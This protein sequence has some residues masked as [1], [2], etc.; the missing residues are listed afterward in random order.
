[1][2][3]LVLVVLLTIVLDSNAKGILVPI[4]SCGKFM[5]LSQESKHAAIFWVSGY[6]SG[7]NEFSDVDYLVN[8]DEEAIKA[9][10]IQY[11]AK[12][13]LDAFSKAAFSVQRQLLESVKK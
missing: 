8:V 9:A 6:V 3:K 10:V 11:C 5:T 12:N 1:M 4:M 13:P 2:K 7:M